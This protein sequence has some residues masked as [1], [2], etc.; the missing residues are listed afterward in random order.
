MREGWDNQDKMLVIS[1]GL[2][3]DKPDHQ[4]GD[5]LGVQAM[6]NSKVILPNYQVRYSLK[7]LELFKNSMVKNVALVDE[8]LQG[9][10]YASNKGGSGFGKFK[11]LPNP[12]TLGWHTYNNTDV[13][14]GS[15]DGFENVGVAYTRQVINVKNDFWIVK[16]NFKSELPHTY[17]QVWQGH[18]SSENGQDLLRSSFDNGSGLDIL[19][20]KQTD[21]IVTSGQ[22]GKEWSVVMKKDQKDYSFI[23]ILFP[24]EKYDQRIAEATPEG[25]LKGWSLNASP[26]VSDNKKITSLTKESTT[27]A[28]TVKE[29]KIDAITVRF[30]QRSDVMIQVENENLQITLLSDEK[31]EVTITQ[32][33]DTMS[34]SLTPASQLEYKIK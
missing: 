15:H 19:Q 32:G 17:K 6:A 23:T 30:S 25:K 27:I 1:A 2:D 8:E 12:T 20:L 33:K 3:P 4:H 5:M 13:F 22:R 10:K 26:M 9:K 14:V 24:F 11:K 31:V 18:Y 21:S 34:K 16:D 7:D 28:F 29:L